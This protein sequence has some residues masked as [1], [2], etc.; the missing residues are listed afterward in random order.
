MILFRRLKL[1]VT[2]G[3]IN[4]YSLS[5]SLIYTLN[6]PFWVFLSFRPS[7]VFPGV[8]QQKN[9]IKTKE[10]VSSHIPPNQSSSQVPPSIIGFYNYDLSL[11]LPSSP[12]FPLKKDF[13]FLIVGG[14][15]ISG[16]YNS[17][18]Q[19]HP[20]VG[21]TRLIVTHGNLIFLTASRVLIQILKDLGSPPC[22]VTQPTQEN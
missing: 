13:Y 11:P 6:S 14:Y 18:P 22:L 16:F 5:Y 3:P 10:R 1:S 21:H 4:N 15:L 8:A 19:T 20:I 9:I 17:L 2:W 12:S 7:I